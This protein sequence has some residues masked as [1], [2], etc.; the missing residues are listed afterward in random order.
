MGAM[1]AIGT[2]GRILLFATCVGGCD[3]AVR[4]QSAG[5]PI[6]SDS[7]APSQSV[8][9]QAE[10]LRTAGQLLPSAVVSAQLD[11]PMPGPVQ[12]VAVQT[13]ALQP[14]E[15]AERARAIGVHIGWYYL[16]P[17]CNRWHAKILGG[18][19]IARDAVVTGYHCV[20]PTKIPM[21]DGYL[22]ALDSS[23]NVRAVTSVLAKN[24]DLD[25]VILRVGGSDLAPVALNDN[26]SPG[27]A[28]F[29]L[30]DPLGQNGYFSQGIV[31]RFCWLHGRKGKPGSLDEM[32]FLRMNVSTEWAPGSSGS[33]V[34]DVCGNVIGH[35]ATISP[36]AEKGRA[37]PGKS[38][39]PKAENKPET[40]IGHDPENSEPKAPAPK[41]VPTDRFNGAVLITL[42]SATPARG[43]QA[44][45][46][47]L[48]Q[49]AP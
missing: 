4:A 48:N 15:I 13:K 2:L 8:L 19:P 44:M 41:P 16:C 27:D 22:I 40:N 17:D 10:R 7:S 18:Y 28:A 23:G 42:H 32:N 20:D 35:V 33:A 46:R 47:A 31:N 25:A 1:N 5:V 39:D 21:R 14:R 11:M 26:V 34:F 12:T 9:D 36:L 3:F 30:S 43:V 45:V 37:S 24:K 38:P 6:E 49:P 29:C